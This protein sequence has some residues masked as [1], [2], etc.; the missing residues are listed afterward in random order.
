MLDTLHNLY[1]GQTAWIVG[2]G[3]SLQHLRAEHFG[4]GP[5]ITI[6]ESILIV[7]ELGLANPIFSMQKDGDAGL[8]RAVYPR[9]D[10][11]VILQRPGYSERSL[12]EHPVRIYVN[13]SQDLN[14][15][16]SEMSVRLC[17]RIAKLM[18]C[19]K[20]VFVCCDSLVNGDMRRLD[21]E[22]RTIVPAN[23][24]AYMFVKP[25]VLK[26]VETMEHDFVL[27]KEPVKA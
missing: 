22:G 7:Q 12:P 8:G 25:L 19:T 23:S 5:I 24:G 9:R 4:E 26:D 11:P 21:V 13:P 16:H 6:N 18:G 14:L 20:I 2:K 10:I 15:L 1:P 3:P 27:P 17:I